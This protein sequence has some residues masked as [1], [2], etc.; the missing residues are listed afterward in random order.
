ML[1]TFSIFNIFILFLVQIEGIFWVQIF[2]IK[3]ATAIMPAVETLGS[4]VVQTTTL[5]CCQT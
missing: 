3:R 1:P 4:K 5:L 2:K